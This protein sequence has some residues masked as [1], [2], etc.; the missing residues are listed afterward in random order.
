MTA[1]IKQTEYACI[2]WFLRL[3]WPWLKANLF[4]L[5]NMLARAAFTIHG[6]VIHS[7]TQ[8]EDKFLA[9]AK[10]MLWPFSTFQRSC[11]DT[12]VVKSK[13]TEIIKYNGRTYVP[14]CPQNKLLNQLKTQQ[15]QRYTCMG[16]IIMLLSEHF[17]RNKWL[18]LRYVFMY[19]GGSFSFVIAH[20]S[21]LSHQ[22]LTWNCITTCSQFQ[23]LE[24]L[25]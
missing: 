14:Q 16:K 7:P 3:S 20:E 13:E 21:W 5:G 18:S 17:F 24:E 10:P 25:Q 15:L 8:S 4:T 2:I 6:G 9:L 23:R 11:E 19:C 1:F 22:D 12:T